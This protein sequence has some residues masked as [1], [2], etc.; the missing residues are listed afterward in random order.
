MSRP[1]YEPSL[2]RSDAEIAYASRQLF[3]RPAPSSPGFTPISFRGEQ[4][5][6]APSITSG[7]WTILKFDEYSN[8]D[9]TVF[10]YDSD[11]DDLTGVIALQLGLFTVNF[12]WQWGGAWTTTEQGGNI[13]DDMNVWQETAAT[14]PRVSG[15]TDYTMSMTKSYPSFE[16]DAGHGAEVYPRFDFSVIQNSGVSR[17]CQGRFEVIYWGPVIVGDVIET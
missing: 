9:L 1:V 7:S 4:W 12:A 6:N 11:G 15:A 8:P 10:D 2:T 14:M 5:N 13:D 16:Y 3:R 17:V